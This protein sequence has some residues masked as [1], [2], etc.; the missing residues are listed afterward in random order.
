MESTERKSFGIRSSDLHI[1]AMILMLCD[2]T[3][4]SLL[5]RQEWLTCVGRIAFPIFA[6]LLAEGFYHTHDV[7]KY[8]LRLL[9]GAVISE[10]PFDLMYGTRA[11]Y[12]YHQNVMWTFLIALL[13]MAGIH[14]VRQKGNL[15][16]T[17]AASAGGI[18]FGFLLGYAAM[19]DYYGIGVVTVLVFYFF[20]GRKWWCFLGQLACLYW[21]N[22][23]LLGGYYYPITIWG[24][25]LELV[26]QGLALLALIPIWLY[27]GEQGFRAKWF[28]YF[29]YGF[30]PVHMLVLYLIQQAI[31]Y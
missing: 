7:K 25:E 5:P 14:Y 29:C 13:L 18:L 21:L 24:H 26:Q 16:L 11:F 28:R 2:H 6:F 4:A 22:V 20:H 27:R 9:I 8:L 30:Y 23:E 15:W 17:L 12:P 31:L 1:L 10:I 3:W 19:V